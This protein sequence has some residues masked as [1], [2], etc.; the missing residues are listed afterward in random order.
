MLKADSVAVA[1]QYAQAKGIEVI[2]DSELGGGQD[3]WVWESKRPSAIKTLE[4]KSN[5]NTELNCY[6]RLGKAGLRSI[7]GFSVPQLI[8]F[9]V[10]LQ[11]IEMTIVRPPFLLDF[12]KSYLDANPDFSDEKWEQWHREG[13]DLFGE[14]KWTEARVVVAALKSYGIY[15]YDVRP[16][17]LMFSD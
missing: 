9:N 1:T 11:I 3:G 15:Y 8:D 14:S 6:Q 5:F 12:A 2:F 10:D 16:W 17:N 4:R 7:R 13:I